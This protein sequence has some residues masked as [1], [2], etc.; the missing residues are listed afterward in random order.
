[1][2]LHKEVSLQ[3]LITYV[4]VFSS[5][6]LKAQV[7]FSDQLSS[8][9]CLSVCLRVCLS[10]HLSVCCLSICNLFTYF[11]CSPE[12]LVQFQ[13]NFAQSI[14]EWRANEGPCPFP[15]GVD[16]K[17]VKLH[18]RNLEI[19]FFRTTGPVSTKLRAK[20]RLVKGIEV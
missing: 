20:H 9:V 15:R 3:S 5:P 11:T 17:I 8:S 19:F 7:S 16:Y 14:F 1:M 12:P 2:V 18:W 10:I 6:E 4:W 13:P